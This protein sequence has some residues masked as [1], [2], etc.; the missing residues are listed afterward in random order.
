MSMETKKPLQD[1]GGPEKPGYEKRD[2]NLPVLLKFGF[3]LAVL[4]LVAFVGMKYTL[5][6]FQRV[7]P[8]G[9]PASPLENTRTLPPGPRLQAK[10]HQELSDYCNTQEQNVTS[11]RWVDQQNGVVQIP[12]DR[13][14]ELVLE[15]GLP[16]RPMS[17]APPGSAGMHQVGTVDSP[18]PAGVEG[19][20]G[21]LVE[22]ERE[23]APAAPEPKQ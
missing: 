5:N 21:Y 19:P 15:Q 1:K 18:L 14:M 9:P 6:Y 3:W 23:A 13:A 2:A 8:L 10:P 7:Q 16:V 4:I 11:Y 12:V 17:S 22:S 20:C